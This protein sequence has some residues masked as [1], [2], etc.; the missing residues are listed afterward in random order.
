[1]AVVLAI[2]QNFKT[3]DVDATETLRG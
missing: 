2:Y 3:I 1:L